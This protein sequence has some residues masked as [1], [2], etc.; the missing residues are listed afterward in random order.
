M[1]WLFLI[2]AVGFFCL[3]WRRLDW[4]IMTAIFLLPSYLVRFKILGYPTTCLEI[5]ILEIVLV[6]FVKNWQGLMKKVGANWRAKK[7]KQPYPFA[8]EIVALLIISVAAV[9]VSNFGLSALG[10]WRAYFIEPLLFYLVALNVLGQEKSLEKF[11]WPLSWSALAVA[12]VAWY[13]K[14]FDLKFLNPV[15]SEAGRATSIFEYS[16]AV[17]LYLAPIVVLLAGWLL[18][19]E[20]REDKHRI[21]KAVYFLVVILVSLMAIV[22]A[23]SD[24]AI[25]GLVAAGA[26]FGILAHKKTMIITLTLGVC[27]AA[28]IYV[29]PNYR[30]YVGNQLTMKNLSGEIRKQQWRETWQMLNQNY[31]WIWGAGLDNYQV[32][33]APFHQAGIFFNKDNDKDFHRLTV[34]NAE[35]RRTHWQPVQV[36]HFPHN[37]F[38]NFWSELGLAGMLLFVWLMVKY[39]TIGFKNLAKFSAKQAERYVVLGLLSVMVAIVIH[40]L[41]D[42]PYFKNDLSV[43]FW[44][45]LGMMGI[46]NLKFKK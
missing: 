4:A 1:M 31:R 5:M 36:Y 13:Q 42:V 30:E 22:F 38:L 43:M 24:G 17:G 2:F 27:M 44:V 18:A 33:V 20:R 12:G 45:F 35:Y 28:T 11:V 26:F 16:N 41:V 3:A 8:W 29:M 19:V 40:G 25:V 34:F 21:A 9:G 39:F 6:W 7:I 46:V 10:V 23:K 37:I 15:W 14:L 32:A